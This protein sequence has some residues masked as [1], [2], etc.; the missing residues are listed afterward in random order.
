[1]VCVRQPP[2]M[3]VL[4]P[5]S[6]QGY[7]STGCSAR[8]RIAGFYIIRAQKVNTILKTQIL[9]FATTILPVFA[10]EPEPRYVP[11]RRGR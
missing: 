4:L 1:M 6:K 7:P 2:A 11:L 9:C 3:W 8:L 5:V 10:L